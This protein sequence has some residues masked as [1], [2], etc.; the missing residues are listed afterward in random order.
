MNKVTKINPTTM[1]Q[2]TKAYSNG[3]FVPR[4]ADLL[5]VTGQLSQDSDGKV[6]APYDMA[7]QARYIFGQIG[8]ILDAAGMSFDDVV[9]TTIFVID[10]TKSSCISPIRDEFF[11]NSK[12]ASSMFGVT[13]LVK[14]ECVVEIEVMAAKQ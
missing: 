9:K 8:K 13:G 2:P 3:I 12:P 11:K 4:D 10:M 1:K 14:P 5:F 6:I 7:E